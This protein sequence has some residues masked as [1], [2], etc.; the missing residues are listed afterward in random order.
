MT[1]DTP[2]DAAPAAAPQALAGVRVLEIGGGAAAAYCGRLLA[3]AGADVHSTALSEALRLAGIV[4]ADDPLEQAYGQW[5]AA[6][7][8]V[9]PAMAQGAP[10]QALS[11][12]FDLV[13]VGEASQC[14]AS[15]LQPRVASVDLSWFGRTGP[16]RDWPGSDLIVQALTGLPQMV[17][18]Q[19]GPPLAHGDRQATMVG[20]VTAYIAACAALLAEATQAPRRLEV[21]IAEANLVLAEM[22]MYFFQRDGLPMRRWGINR[23]APNS[24]V[25]IYPCREGWVGITVATPDQWRALC[26]ALDLRAMAADEGL[27]TRELR[28]GRLDEV[29]QGLCAA[30]ARRTATEWAEVGR[31]YRVP[32]VVVPDADGIL[33]HPV[34]RARG[35][36]ARLMLPGRAV[37]VPR[38]P[39]GL[40]ATPVATRLTPARAASADGAAAPTEAPAARATA[41]H[42]P[43]LQGVTL[44]DFSMGWAGPLASRLLADLG[45]TVVKIEAA[46]YPD[47]W[48]GMNWTPEFIAERGYELSSIFCG[49]NRGKQGVSIDLTLPAGRQVALDLVRGADAVVENQAA[50]VMAKFG[51]DYAQLRA[52]R[53]DVVMASMSCFGT[54]NAWSGTRAYG[55]TLEQGS[56]LPSFTGTPGTAPTMTHLAHGD[57]VGGLYGCAGLLTALVHRRRHG[58]GQY[59]NISMVEAMLQFTTPAL[60]AHQLAPAAALRRGNRRGF[61]VPHGIYPAAGEDQWLA[62]E[63]ADDAGFAALCG[64]LGR[65]EWAH[66]PALRTLEGRRQREDAIDAAIADW[67][68]PQPA[69]SAATALRAA[70]IGAAALLRAD[71]LEG[72]PDLAGTDLFVDMDRAVS[73]PQRQIGPA[74]RQNGQRLGAHS[75]APLLGEHSQAAL[76]AHAGIGRARFDALVAEGVIGLSP[77]PARNLV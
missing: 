70:G 39:F 16:R 62:L 25:G 41:A 36:L 15:A 24:P 14:D 45:A 43:P 2:T 26:E 67:S 51:L 40:S 8:T 46:R 34:F 1:G 31:E 53:P 32:I 64:L 77:K 13:L 4:R 59:V 42:A 69:A 18:T 37:Q 72:D 7:K 11:R 54:G 50:G 68:R 3:D 63:V 5:L 29:E 48:R 10:L 21:A 22:H 27:A 66:D 38:T 57:P 65:S 76:Q 33:A 12:S 20:G 49:M 60:L 74:I 75:P 71:Q 44:V 55:S 6:G 19:E 23:F 28:F 58:H 61:A 35:S 47:W 52:V 73:G 17:G 9:L 56:G 30:L